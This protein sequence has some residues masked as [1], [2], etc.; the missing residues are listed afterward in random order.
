M[1]AEG[2]LEEDAWSDA[3]PG[4]GGCG[5]VKLC[6]S[7]WVETTPT[8]AR[9]AASGSST[10][11]GLTRGLQRCQGRRGNPT[12]PAVAQVQRPGPMLGQIHVRLGKQPIEML[13]DQKTP[14]TQNQKT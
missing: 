3:P 9:W 2:G 4:L 8:D 5:P 10:C 13:L 14:K 1:E 12:N 6:L 7:L 11:T